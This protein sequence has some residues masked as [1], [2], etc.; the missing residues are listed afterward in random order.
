VEFR[1]N[2]HHPRA[3]PCP[4]I[5]RPDGVLGVSLNPNTG[6][7]VMMGVEIVFESSASLNFIQI[8]IT[9]IL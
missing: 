3:G 6:D 2:I 1:V 8:V 9:V 7:V 4:R 5:P